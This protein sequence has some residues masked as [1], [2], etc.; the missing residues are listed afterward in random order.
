MRRTPV[1][2][3]LAASLLAFAALPDA[4]ADEPLFGYSYTTDTQPRGQYELEQWM[5]FRE[6]RS[7]GDFH[8]WQGR[9]EL[10]YGLT[11]DVQ[12]SGYLNLAYTSVHD[13]TPDGETAPPE[14]FA[15]YAVDPDRRFERTRFESVS[16]EVLWRL[17]SPYL[18]PVGVALYFEPSLGPRTYEAEARL[19]LQSNFRD[20]RLVFAG[21]I[22][23]A[24]EGR[25]LPG[26]FGAMPGTPEAERVWDHEVDVN[27]DIGGSYRFAPN[28]SAGLE[29]LNER[30]WA[31][32]NA[33]NA[34]NRTNSAYYFGPNIHY[35]GKKYFFTATFLKQLPWA[36]DYANPAP[37]FI[38]KG[39]TNADDFEKYR[40]RVKAGFNF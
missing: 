31:G 20:D 26:E 25:H 35:G 10:S 16:G 14:V 22:T 9:T 11:D 27:Y 32:F 21:N 7:Q 18:H 24:I 37:G 38:V 40:L 3:L 33:F 34:S 29:L 36:R 8:L 2:I 30:E 6:G 28:F 13:N 5:T 23:Y 4:L 12:I 19:I 39:I 1:S 17:V 15:D